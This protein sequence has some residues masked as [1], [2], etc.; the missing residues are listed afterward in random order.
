MK[1]FNILVFPCGSEIGLE[2]HRSLKYSAHINL[3][4]A[5]SVDDHGKFIYEKYIGGLPFIDSDE[6]ISKLKCLIKQHGID[7]IYP[8]MDSV[9]CKLKKHEL[10]LGCKIISSKTETTEVCLSKSKTYDLLKDIMKTPKVYQT[11]K[12][13]ENYPIFIKPDVGYGTRD[14]HRATSLEEANFFLNRK[15]IKYLLSEYLPGNEYTIDCFTDRKGRLLFAGPRKR[16]R[17]MNGISVNTSPENEWL[18]EL[19]DIAEAINKKMSLRGAWFFQTKMDE[20][21]RLTL[22]EVA[23]RIGGSSSLYRGL[24][25]NFA[26]LSVFDAFDIDVEI[27]TNKYEIEMD[28]ALSNKYRTNLKYD[29]VYVDFD[30]CLVIHDK[31]NSELMAFLYRA[32][33]NGTKIV[34]L[35]KHEGDLEAAMQRHRV[36]MLFDEVIHIKKNDQK[37]KFIK[38]KSGIFIDD[39]FVERKEIATKLGWPTFA[40]DMIEL[41]QEH[42]K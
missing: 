19:N 8:A 7:A 20:N 12:E 26:L 13:V 1:I 42:E 34:L 32:L 4:G 35:T 21:G 37:Y 30:D 11:T 14:T 3:M 28:R 25:V 29:T 33:N 16:N 40:P 10:E 38:D 27:I 15:N 23:S 9:I 6:I 41:L 31:I 5:S 17:V 2:I 22:M 24:G 18:K 36:V 39:S